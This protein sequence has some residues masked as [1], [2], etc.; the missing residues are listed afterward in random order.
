MTELSRALEVFGL[1]KDLFDQMNKK[2]LKTFV[3]ASIN[4]LPTQLK[5]NY[6]QILIKAKT[7]KVRIKEPIKSVYYKTQTQAYEA[8]L[9]PSIDI[10][11]S[12]L[13]PPSN[14]INA[15]I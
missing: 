14:N 3:I 11:F 7:K 9:G 10:L 1:D 13:V 15:W 2:D 6:G 5:S 8:P 4:T 12:S